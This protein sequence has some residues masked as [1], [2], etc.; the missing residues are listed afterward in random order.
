VLC[1]I[2]EDGFEKHAS[3]LIRGVQRQDLLCVREGE[4]EREGGR[5]GG[6]ERER[7]RE[8]ERGREGGRES[9]CVDSL[10]KGR[11]CK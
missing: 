4:R 7:E 6:R 5:E 1:D 9:E 3:Q 8:R 10:L 11:S 2:R